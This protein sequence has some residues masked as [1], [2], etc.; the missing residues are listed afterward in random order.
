MTKKTKNILDIFVYLEKKIMLTIIGKI[1]NGVGGMG[2]LYNPKVV[3][4]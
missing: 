1:S 3:V 4:H 2:G